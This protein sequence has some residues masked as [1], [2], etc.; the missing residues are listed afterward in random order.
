MVRHGQV[1][2]CLRV[3]G[4]VVE[5]H[6]RKAVNG[7][8]NRIAANGCVQ[9]VPADVRPI[10]VKRVMQE[11]F[12]QSFRSRSESR[13]ERKVRRV[14]AVIVVVSIRTFRKNAEFNGVTRIDQHFPIF[15]RLAAAIRN[16][17]V[18]D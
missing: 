11:R 3:S 5:R 4:R 2:R 7:F 13:C 18:E 1:L 17:F 15:N 12:W 10:S 6:D 8:E 9:G 14:V 16:G